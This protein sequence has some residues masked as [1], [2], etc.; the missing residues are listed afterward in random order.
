MEL[1]DEDAQ[2]IGERLINVLGLEVTDGYVNTNA[3]LKTPIGLAR[4]VDAVID[5]VIKGL[6]I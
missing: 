5:D 2:V 4:T 3:G 6:D 1:N